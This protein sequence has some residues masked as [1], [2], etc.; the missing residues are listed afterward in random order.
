VR[1]NFTVGVQEKRSGRSFTKNSFPHILLMMVM[2]MMMIMIIIIII[3][4]VSSFSD[5]LY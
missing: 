5:I 1:Q 4:T 3:T 2:A